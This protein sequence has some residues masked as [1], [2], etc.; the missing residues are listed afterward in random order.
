MR[1]YNLCIGTALESLDFKSGD[2]IE[3]GDMKLTNVKQLKATGERYLPDMGL[4]IAL[5]H[6]HRYFLATELVSGKVVLDIASGEGYGTHYLARTAKKVYGIDISQEAVDHANA[7]YS[8]DNIEFLQGSATAIPL[9]SDSVDIIVSFETVE[10]IN[11]EQ[12]QI[13]LDEIRRVLH[14]NGMLVISTPDKDVY[15]IARNYT[16]PY[17]LSEFTAAG[18]SEYLTAA[19][20]NVHFLRQRAGLISLIEGNDTPQA[21]GIKMGDDGEYRP[22]DDKYSYEYIIAV[23]SLEDKPTPNFSASI[24]FDTWDMKSQQSRSMIDLVAAK[25]VAEERAQLIESM[26]A[27]QKKAILDLD[28]KLLA[29][30]AVAEERAQ[31]LEGFNFKHHELEKQ[32]IMASALAEERAQEIKHLSSKLENCQANTAK[33]LEETR[34][35]TSKLQECELSAARALEELMRPQNYLRALIARL[36]NKVR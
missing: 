6:W 15:S 8:G 18:F 5:E 23:C 20:S 26:V 12:Q 30:Q 31:L 32:Y 17:H 33:A 22:S 3:S 9:A 24:T 29:A 1:T 19:F 11:K 36:L 28:E 27:Q 4:Q 21:Y 16:N 10:H 35:L 25:A 14:P 13:F 34:C 7:T 2:G